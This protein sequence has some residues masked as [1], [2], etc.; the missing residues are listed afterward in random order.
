[1]LNII[2]DIMYFI[3]SIFLYIIKYNICIYWDIH[4]NIFIYFFNFAMQFE[5]YTQSL[6]SS[7]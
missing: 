2:F 6:Q 1:M 3:T 4:D 7:V 5:H